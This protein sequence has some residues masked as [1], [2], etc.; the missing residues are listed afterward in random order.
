MKKYCNANI[1]LKS[2]EKVERGAGVELGE[3]G[4]GPCGR[5]LEAG[6]IA[7]DNGGKAGYPGGQE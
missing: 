6:S 7:C 3:K 2:Q 4:G 5:E 1:D